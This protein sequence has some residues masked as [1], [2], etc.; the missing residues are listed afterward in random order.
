LL[1]SRTSLL[2]ITLVALLALPAAALGKPRAKKPL[3]AGLA[4]EVLSNRADVISAG[5]ALVAVKIPAG[6][7]ASKVRVTAGGRD[8]TSAFATRPDGRFEGLVTDLVVGRNALTASAPGRQ[9]ASTTIVNHPNGGPVLSGPQIQ[10]WVC[11]EGA[12]DAQCNRPV[13]VT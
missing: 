13:E 2:V 10:P 6:V 4:V 5:D 7:D 3:P 11:Q 12:T 9:S 8:V 1:P